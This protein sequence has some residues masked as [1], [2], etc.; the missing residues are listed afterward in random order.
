MAINDR[1]ELIDDRHAEGGFG[2]ISKQ[3]DKELE[4]YVAVKELKLLDDHEA[5]ERFKREAKTLAHLNHPNIPAIYDVQ[6]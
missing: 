6:F 1:Y 4:R 3:R 5:R 2:R